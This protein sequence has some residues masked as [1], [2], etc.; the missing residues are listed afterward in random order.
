MR[1]AGATIVQYNPATED[2]ESICNQIARDTGKTVIPPYNHPHVIAGQGTA[3]LELIENAGS[4]DAILAPCGGGG[5][6]SGTAISTKS[7]LPHCK[8]YGV[9]PSQADDAARSFATRTLCS[10]HHPQTIADGTHAFTW[11]AHIPSRH[12]VG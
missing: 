6:L 4:F 2:R 12:G 9:E 11:R 3:A 8:V 10:V 7:L 1:R 5:L